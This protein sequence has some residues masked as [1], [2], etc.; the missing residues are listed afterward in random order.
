MFSAVKKG[1][2]TSLVDNEE[3][4]PQSK[5]GHRVCAEGFPYFISYTSD[6]FLFSGWD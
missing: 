3:N 1:L 4:S 6:L 2:E 5:E